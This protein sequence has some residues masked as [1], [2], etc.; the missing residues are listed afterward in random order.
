MKES[1]VSLDPAD[2]QHDGLKT[3]VVRMSYD[4]ITRTGRL[5]MGTGCCC[6]MTGCIELFRGIDPKALRI[7]TFAG[8][9][10][11]TIYRR[12]PSGEFND[13]DSNQWIAEEA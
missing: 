2:F 4:W 1:T 10:P 8:N 6:D 13:A 3:A 11:D 12:H 7:E 9:V 5:V